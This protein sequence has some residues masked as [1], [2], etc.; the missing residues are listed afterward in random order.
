MAEMGIALSVDREH[1]RAKVERKA[2]QIIEEKELP[3]Y[4]Y[5]T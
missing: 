5:E 3:G 2:K 4:Y 1:F